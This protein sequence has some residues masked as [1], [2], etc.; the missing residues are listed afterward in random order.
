MPASDTHAAMAKPKP[1]A[2]AKAGPGKA[3]GEAQA[4]GTIAVDWATLVSLSLLDGSSLTWVI[5]SSIALFT[6]QPQLKKI[7]PVAIDRAI[8]E[9][10][11][12]ERRQACHHEVKGAVIDVTKRTTR[13]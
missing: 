11:P 2:G 9:V 6:H 10:L 5:P 12:C 1:K 4:K 3:S 8:R 7:V 13:M